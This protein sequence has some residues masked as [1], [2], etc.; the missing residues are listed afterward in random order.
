VS[1]LDKIAYF[2]ITRGKAVISYLKKFTQPRYVIAFVL[3]YPYI[4]THL[5][6]VIR[7]TQVVLVNL[8]G[9]FR[10]WIEAVFWGVYYFL[11]E[12]LG[13]IWF[14]EQIAYAL[15]GI[16]VAPLHLL[17]IILER[18]FIPVANVIL[19]ISLN[20]LGVVFYLF[21]RV[22]I[23]A[24][25]MAYGAYLFARFMPAS[26]KYIAK[27]L[28]RFAQ[29]RFSGFI[30]ALMGTLAPFSAF[31]IGPLII[32]IVTDP[33]CRYAYA[34]LT[35]QPPYQVPYVPPTVY[36]FTL[37]PAMSWIISMLYGQYFIPPNI[38]MSYI[39]TSALWY[40]YSLVSLSYIYSSLYY[41]HIS[42]YASGYLPPTI[43]YILAEAPISSI[44]I[45]DVS[46]ITGPPYI[47]AYVQDL[48]Y[49]TG[50]P[51][52]YAY[53]YDFSYF[54]TPPQ[55]SAY[56]HDFSYIAAPPVFEAKILD[57]SYL[58]PR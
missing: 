53:I 57:L 43:S 5:E 51:Y 16:A 2:L 33:V 42:G 35:I 13:N 30:G 47:Y 36:H 37:D 52:V 38:T 40:I 55:I 14:G 31:F 39:D 48:S 50:P 58:V 32:S 7:E 28:D 20:V 44:S 8:A 6:T 4:Y 22:V 12:K 24:L 10:S 15:A 26:Y 19:T 56:I 23:P 25:K 3:I 46:H 34:P 41:S 11:R 49:I 27:A 45:R 21:C 18:V 29:G 1:F 9:Q 54:T 17:H